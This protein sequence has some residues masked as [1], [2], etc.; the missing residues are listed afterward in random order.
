MKIV[1]RLLKW[2]AIAHLT[3]KI[4]TFVIARYVLTWLARSHPAEFD[5]SMKTAADR[6]GISEAALYRRLHR[7]GYRGPVPSSVRRTGF[8]SARVS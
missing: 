5:E 3:T 4:S 6:Q 1:V 8:K 7:S 2:L